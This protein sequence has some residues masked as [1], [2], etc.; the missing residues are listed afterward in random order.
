MILHPAVVIHGLDHVRTALRPGR[1]V[2]LL[3]AQGAALFAGCLWWRALIEHS[4][5]EFPGAVTAD[6]LDCADAPGYAMAAL[7]VGQRRL[8]LDPACPAFPAVAAA[9]SRL[10]ADVLPCRPPALDLGEAG[11]RRQ[12]ETWLQREQPV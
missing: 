5:A 12:L 1:P 11:A 4:Q 2:I 6:L 10:G 8:V 9:A 3:S 7:R